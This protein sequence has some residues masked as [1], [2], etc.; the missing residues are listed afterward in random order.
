MWPRSHELA[1][2]GLLL[3]LLVLLRAAPTTAS[4]VTLTSAAVDEHTFVLASPRKSGS[5]LERYRAVLFRLR[6]N[7]TLCQRGFLDNPHGPR[8]RCNTTHQSHALKLHCD[9]LD[10]S[11]TRPALA[12]FQL[13][14]LSAPPQGTVLRMFALVFK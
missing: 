7:A 11:A 13:D 14:L 8:E 4:V 6:F 5:V 10:G 12:A 1:A 2:A 3:L 9:A